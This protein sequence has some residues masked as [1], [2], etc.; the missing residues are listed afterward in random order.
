MRRLSVLLVLAVV[1]GLLPHLL[2]SQLS[3]DS[4]LIRIAE[5]DRAAHDGDRFRLRLDLY[6]RLVSEGQLAAADSLLQVVRPLVGTN[7]RKGVYIQAMEML[8][9]LRKGKADAAWTLG[10]GL[11]QQSY[12][13]V[14]GDLIALVGLHLMRVGRQGERIDTLVGLLEADYAWQAARKRWSDASLAINHA[15]ILSAERG[16]FTRGLRNFEKVLH[17]AKQEGAIPAIAQAQVNIGIARTE[18]GD[19]RQGLI[20]LEAARRLLDSCACNPKGLAHV[21]M[22]IGATQI[23]LGDS[24]GGYRS[25][26]RALAL[27]RPM[28]DYNMIHGL[29]QQL[30]RHH[31]HRRQTDSLNHYLSESRGL[32]R[33]LPMPGSQ[34]SQ[35]LL[36]ADVAYSQGDYPACARHA[37]AAFALYEQ[38][39]ML[40]SM[41]DATRLRYRADSASGNYRAA[42]DRYQLY[43]QLGDSLQSATNVRELGRLEA[44]IEAE[45]QAAHLRAEQA[46][47]RER[48][49]WFLG[50]A[51]GGL[52]LLSMIAFILL[53][54]RNKQQKANQ[55]LRELNQEIAHKKTE[56]EAQHEEITLI[57][58]ELQATLTEVSSQRQALEVQNLRVED[59]I[60]YASRIQ[61]AILPD[62]RLLARAL[63]P[64]TIHYQPRDIVS[65]DFYWAAQVG[66]LSLLA[67]VDCTG[68]GVPGAFMSVVGAN[69]L[70]QI[71][72]QEGY[73]D[74]QAIL[75]E[76]DRRIIEMLRQ[77]LGGATNDGMD[78][79]LVVLHPPSGGSRRMDFASGGR[80]LWWL[81][82]EE[83]LEIKSGKHGCGG[84]QQ[85]GK[86]FPT[87]T[88]TVGAGERLYL[89]SDGVTDQFGGPQGRK[90][91]TARLREWLLHSRQQ[92]IVEQG[93]AFA[94]FFTTWQG[95]RR[96]LDDVLFVGLDAL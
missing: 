37:Q 44:R 9:L 14:D 26:H 10:L 24:L 34:A 15:A 83:L 5:A 48:N 51:L 70:Q 17:A 88:R 46:T 75:A 16:D 45:R 93:A 3:R 69:L 80:P 60:R 6:Q 50:S 79:G 40:A 18:L 72:V 85:T 71:V 22:T 43:R 55:V 12:A 89:F 62:A 4:L 91:G 25:L 65:G 61:R 47:E 64:H 90:L 86:T 81:R 82:G 58:A 20:E 87:Q 42:L 1:L 56:I 28:E 77:E 11:R 29:V 57:N 7:F 66:G 67:T 13:H 30:S 94:D 33:R 39:D 49:R 36:E 76:L 54:S 32:V 92:S 41:R 2:A 84:R 95:S 52:G 59:S 38:L 35:H 96:Q 27:Y 63:P 73:L 23:G 21:H 74:P 78:L 31:L 19:Q 68:H 8:G 53:R